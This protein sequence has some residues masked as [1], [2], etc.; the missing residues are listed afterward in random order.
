MNQVQR[1]VAR[2]GHRHTATFSQFND[3]V[4]W[5]CVTHEQCWTP[6]R[7]LHL[8][9]RQFV[10]SIQHFT[11]DVI[12]ITSYRDINIMYLCISFIV[13]YDDN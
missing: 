3:T 1:F 8:N 2:S 13:E 9:S 7:I 12:Q 4:L 11:W 6:L 10:V 5:I